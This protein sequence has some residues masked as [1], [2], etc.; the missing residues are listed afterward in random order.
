MD[1]ND[2]SILV[3]ELSSFSLPAVYTKEV[4]EDKTELKETDIENYVLKQSKTL[5]DLGVGMTQDL[6]GT[7]VQS[8]NPDDVAALAEIMNATSKLI[9]T[10]HKSTLLDKK[11]QKDEKLKKLDIESRKEIAQ[12]KASSQ[13]PTN[14]NVLIASR[15]EIMKKLFPKDLDTI[16]LTDSKVVDI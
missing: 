2:I 8:Q 5:I 12:L 9:D 4:Q 14:M 1:S 6:A 13:Q 10:L 15:E 16:E 3:D 7:A 11:A